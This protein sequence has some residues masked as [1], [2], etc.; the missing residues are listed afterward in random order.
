MRCPECHKETKRR[1]WKGE[2]TLMGVAVQAR[3]DQC[4]ACEGLL[5]DASE[6]ERVDRVAAAAV[7]R[8]GVQTSKEF[9]FVRKTAGLRAVDV[10]DLLGVRPETVSRWER[11]EVEIPRAIAF[12]LGELFEHP[13]AAKEKLETLAAVG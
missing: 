1:P 3:G 13:K 4:P 11:G 12:V 10:A 8:R 2:V 9:R 6:L 7:V 5:F